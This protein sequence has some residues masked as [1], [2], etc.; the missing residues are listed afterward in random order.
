MFKKIAIKMY[1]DELPKTQLRQI[2]FDLLEDR[3]IPLKRGCN[4]IKQ[5][6]GE[7]GCPQNP[8]PV[9]GI[10][11]EFIY[12]NRLKSKLDGAGYLFHRLCSF[13]SQFTETPIDLFELVSLT[14]KDWR[15]ICFTPYY[16]RRSRLAPSF[17]TFEP[18]EIGENKKYY[19]I[20]WTWDRGYASGSYYKVNDFPL[21][22]AKVYRETV[23]NIL[24]I[25][26]PFEPIAY[27]DG[28][29]VF[30]CANQIH[31]NQSHI[32]DLQE[33][34]CSMAN[35]IE[36]S[37]RVMISTALRTRQ[38]YLNSPSDYYSRAI[39]DNSLM[40]FRQALAPICG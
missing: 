9:N 39:K 34:A 15:Q 25:K 6:K 33:R 36:N 28:I 24:I 3:W 20:N 38:E 17:A 7:F 8:I 22:L 4:Q 21:D 12:L 16:S 40:H 35:N 30:R 31:I 1:N 13:H 29:P 5:G 10:K 32:R 11:G 2:E 23:F 14:G 18:L 27:D 37:V 26:G 19:E